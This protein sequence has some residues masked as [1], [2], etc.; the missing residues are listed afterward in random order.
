MDVRSLGDGQ[1]D[2]VEWQYSAYG[3]IWHRIIER[4]LNMTVFE[5]R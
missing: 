3:I 2:K 1:D 5:I 4:P